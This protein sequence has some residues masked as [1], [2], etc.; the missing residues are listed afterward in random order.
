MQKILDTAPECDMSALGRRVAAY[1][2]FALGVLMTETPALPRT[3]PVLFARMK[4]GQEDN[5]AATD[6]WSRVGARWRCLL[7]VQK[8]TAL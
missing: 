7:L 1:T 5:S 8:I 4:R 6:V 3:A 2:C